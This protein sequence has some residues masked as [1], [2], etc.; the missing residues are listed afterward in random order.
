MFFEKV[1]VV[2]E[3]RQRKIQLSPPGPL[4]TD[5]LKNIHLKDPQ[6]PIPNQ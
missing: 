6:S 5:N 3:T 4:Q 1:L 2:S